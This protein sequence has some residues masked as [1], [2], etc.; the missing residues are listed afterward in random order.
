MM[1][2]SLSIVF[3]SMLATDPGMTERASVIAYQHYCGSTGCI[4]GGD[5]QRAYVHAVAAGTHLFPLFDLTLAPQSYATTEEVLHVFSVLYGMSSGV[6]RYIPAAR[7]LALSPDP[8]SAA[9]A[10][11][12]LA[13]HGDIT[14]V[15]VA[16]MFLVAR[17]MC[18]QSC[19]DILSRFGGPED[20]ALL[21]GRDR[22]SWP[23]Y[24]RWRMGREHDGSRPQKP[25]EDACPT[26]QTATTS[27]GAIQCSQLY[28]S[29]RRCYSPELPRWWLR[30]SSTLIFVR[31]SASRS[32]TGSK[33]HTP[34]PPGVIRFRSLTCC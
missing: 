2:V 33:A 19:C 10:L 8:D 23:D 1:G 31:N 21:E 3:A 27:V 17:P 6:E 34:S 29:L 14:D 9:T 11:H 12:F 25:G 28:W 26:R 4:S 24:L 15:K 20:A 16:L 18:S 7:R 5:S 22:L 13:R 32:T 30:M